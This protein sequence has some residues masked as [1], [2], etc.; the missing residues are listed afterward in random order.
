MHLLL[1]RHGESV[2]NVAGLYA[3][4]RD[5]ALTNHGVLQ[6]RRLGAHLV[7][8]RDVIGPVVH[9]F[10]SNL[11]RA[12][13]TAEAV[14]DAQRGSKAALKKADVELTVAQLPELREKDFGSAEGVKYGVLSNGRA[15]GSI[16][17]DSE[18]REAMMVRVD[19]FIDKELT[20]MLKRHA[21]E[22]VAVVVVAHGIILGVL[23]QA[24]VSHF[25][26][27][28]ASTAS[29]DGDR[30]GAAWSN[31][32]VL[33][34]KIENISAQVRAS[35]PMSSASTTVD[36]TADQSRLTI[37]IQGTN[38]TDHLNGL[39]KTRGGIGSAKFDS[40]QQTLTAF[41]TPT[42]KKRKAEDDLSQ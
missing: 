13:R 16:Q 42:S 5:S 35:G 40:R 4:S 22:K 30:Y 26:V 18:S 37:V 39:K 32:G 21:S 11:Q 20:P 3:G 23:L 17:S 34:A 28:T 33:Q 2:D 14:A 25:P 9:I 8:R 15:D 6:A 31:T 10:T 19:R 12:Y 27:P 38:L 41:F 1:I 29:A 36:C 24:L 7:S